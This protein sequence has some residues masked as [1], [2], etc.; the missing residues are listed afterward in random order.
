MAFDE[1]RG[2]TLWPKGVDGRGIDNA[3]VGDERQG[4]DIE[5]RKKLFESSAS[6][7]KDDRLIVWAGTGVGSVTSVMTAADIVREIH[8]EGV[9]HIR[10]AS[11]LIS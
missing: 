4:L 8:T 11:S 3:I 7:G 1:V 9:K 2:T 6:Q 5:E 10:A